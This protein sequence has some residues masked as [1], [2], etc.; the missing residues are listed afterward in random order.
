MNKLKNLLLNNNK[1]KFILKKS[2]I[3]CS[4]AVLKLAILVL[5]FRP[6]INSTFIETQQSLDTGE[7]IDY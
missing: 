6:N 7:S 2:I 3:I 1:N 5:F 4:A